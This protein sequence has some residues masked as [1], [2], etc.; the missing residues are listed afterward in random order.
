M[1]FGWKWPFGRRKSTS[2]DPAAEATPSSE[3]ATVQRSIDV[4]DVAETDLGAD[5]IARE[6]SFS[7]PP[8][9][10]ERGGLGIAQN[11]SGAADFIQRL[12]LPT[13]EGPLSLA[14]V[15]DA[16]EFV[17]SLPALTSFTNLESTPVLRG[18]LPT[19]GGLTDELPPLGSLPH[20]LPGLIGV[21]PETPDVGVSS[22]HSAAPTSAESTIEPVAPIAFTSPVIDRPAPQASEPIQRVVAPMEPLAVPSAPIEAARPIESLLLLNDFAESLPLISTPSDRRGAEVPIGP[23]TAPSDLGQPIKLTPGESMAALPDRPH[24]LLRLSP[25]TQSPID[26][27]PAAQLPGDKPAP[28]G[29]PSLTISRYAEELPL[30]PSSAHETPAE[31]AAPPSLITPPMAVP[32]IVEPTTIPTLNAFA[33]PMPLVGRP[34][35]P[36][37]SLSIIEEAKPAAQSPIDQSPVARLPGD[38]STSS[39]EPSL[40]ISRYAEE[41][42][43]PSLAE[44]KA[45]VEQ[46]TPPSRITPPMAAPS[47]VEPTTIPT[48]DAFAE[49]MPLVGWLEEPAPSLSKIEE[50]RPAAQSP[51]GQPPIDQLPVAQLPDVQSP[52]AAEPPLAISR[53]AEEM[54]LI[55]LNIG[56]SEDASLMNEPSIVV[57]PIESLQ[58]FTS[59]PELVLPLISD[60]GAER[61]PSM[62]EAPVSIGRAA[63]AAPSSRSPLSIGVTQIQ[64]MPLLGGFSSL[65]QNLPSLGGLAQNLPVLGGLTQGL[66]SMRGLT[67][68]LPSLGGLSEGLSSLGSLAQSLPSLGGLTSPEMPLPPSINEAIGGLGGAA[69]EA[70]GQITS[71][72]PSMSEIPSMPQLP[73]IEK[74]ADQIWREIQKKLKVERERTRGLA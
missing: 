24:D 11:V 50:A 67:D 37:P 39:G 12:P 33:E 27:L 7:T 26:Q 60:A 25:I 35:E 49:P 69:Q 32:P 42:P 36:A 68:H 3:P 30:P 51:I 13:G 71:M 34:E 18:E 23:T 17:A 66:P 4:A 45:P 59:A 73:S 19:P 5:L 54:P 9:L 38:Q 61:T 74:L 29:E 21:A 20:Q 53:Y 47:I 10:G 44:S 57:P 8:T 43:L 63:E 40:T 2:P 14:S 41:L 31:Q 1:P 28:S 46:A 48:L 62:S 65:T 22:I 64:R 6:S 56:V 15:P 55:D 72:A 58:E 52:L 70:M 16:R